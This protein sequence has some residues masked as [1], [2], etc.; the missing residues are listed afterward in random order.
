[1][2]IGMVNK[3]IKRRMRKSAVARAK[4][5]RDE[6]RVFAPVVKVEMGNMRWKRAFGE[7]GASDVA[8]RCDEDYLEDANDRNDAP[9]KAPALQS[10]EKDNSESTELTISRTEER[11]TK[12]GKTS[13]ASKKSSGE[14]VSKSLK[15]ARN[16]KNSKK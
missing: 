1:M 12:K 9:S 16:Q 4:R 8:D 6:G 5:L 2:K 14:A 11:R 7:M 13:V 10:P 3:Q 15:K